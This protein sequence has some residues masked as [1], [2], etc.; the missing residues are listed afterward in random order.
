VVNVPVTRAMRNGYITEPARADHINK[1]GIDGDRP[2]RTV[3]DPQPAPSESRN[4][5]ATITPCHDYASASIPGGRQYHV[6]LIIMMIITGIE[7]S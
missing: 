3:G 4:N 6:S 1:P 2:T 7:S 5:L